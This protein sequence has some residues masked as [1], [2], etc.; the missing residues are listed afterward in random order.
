MSRMRSRIDKPF[1]RHEIGEISGLHLR[2]KPNGI[3]LIPKV[4]RSYN[5]AIPVWFI[6]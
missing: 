6:K 3:S 5:K 1:I 4:E 2:I